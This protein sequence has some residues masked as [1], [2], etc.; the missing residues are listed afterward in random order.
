M[1][2]RGKNYEIP[3]MS[4]AYL[5]ILHQSLPDFDNCIMVL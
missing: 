1:T 5:I 2:L 4:V 3:G